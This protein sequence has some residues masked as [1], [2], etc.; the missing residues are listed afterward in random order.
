[1]TTGR[2]NQVTTKRARAPTKR[3]A[4]VARHLDNQS[5]VVVGFDGRTDWQL[6]RALHEPRRKRQKATLPRVPV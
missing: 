3:R 1:M 4:A 6:G 5:G 2:I